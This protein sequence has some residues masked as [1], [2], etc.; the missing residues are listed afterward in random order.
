MLELGVSVRRSACRIMKTIGRVTAFGAVSC[1]FGYL[2]LILFLNG[3]VFST[4][5]L[6]F[7]LNIY[8]VA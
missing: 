1:N 3:Y 7:P 5:P 2:F 6:L 4:Q 8:A